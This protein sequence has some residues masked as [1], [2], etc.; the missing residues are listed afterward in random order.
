M[1]GGKKILQNTLLLTLSSVVNLVISI[2][3]T[4]IIARSIGPEL[5]GRYTFSLTY[6][7]MFS[8]LAN[9]GLESL[10]IREAARDRVNL[11]FIKDI[12]HLKIILAIVTIGTLLFSAHILNYNSEIISVLYI[13]CCGLFFQILS[14]SLLS[15]YRSVEKMHVTAFFSTFFRI[16]SAIVIG[17]SVYFGLGFYGIVSAFSIGNALVF[18]AVLILF[19]R[20]FRLLNLRISPSI[21]FNLIRQGAPFYFSALLTMFYAKINI[22]I[23]SKLASEREIGYYMAALNLVENLY[24]IPTAFVTSAFPAFSRLYGSSPDALKSAYIKMTKYLIILTVAVSIGTVLVSDNIVRLIYGDQFAPA[25][26]VLNVLIFLWV[27]AFFS[28]AQSSLLF[29]IQKE[30]AQVKIMMIA[31]LVNAVLNFVFIRSYGYMGAAIAS[32]LT[33]GIVVVLISYVLWRAGFK[34]FPDISIFRLVVAVAGMIFIVRFLS[35]FNIAIAIVGGAVSYTCLLFALK[36]FDADDINYM[37]TLFRR[38]APN[39]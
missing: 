23:L 24:F 6:I 4:S 15:V 1:I 22:V 10:F 38:N 12:F 5:Y 37:K 36:V 33:E 31:V 7:L 39:G 30:R 25:V 8:V 19:R 13:L 9:F 20:D 29:S 3:T 11:A 28:N 32:V 18:M 16:V 21:W 27:L 34:Y 2:A 35:Q 17:L 26:P 14:E